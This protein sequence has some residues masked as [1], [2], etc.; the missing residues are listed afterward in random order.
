MARCCSR[1]ILGCLPRWRS[2]SSCTLPVTWRSFSS[3]RL[4]EVSILPLVALRA[5][6]EQFRQMEAANDQM[7]AEIRAD[8]LGVEGDVAFHHALLAAA[9]NKFLSQFGALLQKFFRQ[10]RRRM[11]A[12]E[13]EARRSLGEHRRIVRALRERDVPRAQ[14]LMEEHLGHYQRR[15]VIPQAEP[16]ETTAHGPTA[17]TRSERSEP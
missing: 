2:S 4:L 15:G 13:T 1:S 3:R 6:E 16:P 10:A 12:N 11:L 17:A 8:G 14:Q 5:T 7:E 9:R